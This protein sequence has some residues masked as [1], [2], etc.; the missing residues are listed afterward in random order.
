MARRTPDDPAR[1]A[2][3]A[4]AIR[5]ARADE[6][7]T[8]TAIRREAILRL[9]AA[10]MGDAGAAAWA[11]SAPPDRVARAIAGSEV[12]VADRSG[13]PVGWVEIERNRIEGL[14]VRPGG[15][16]RGIGSALLGHAEG[17]IRSAG[18]VEARLDASPNAETFYARRGYERLAERDA[19]DRQPMRKA[20]GA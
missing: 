6:A 19:D 3:A 4:L 8:L 1:I 15:A 9:A 12:W 18:H 10:Q 7:Q 13:D 5:R 16:Q 17:R 2:A 14:Y 20:L 11:S